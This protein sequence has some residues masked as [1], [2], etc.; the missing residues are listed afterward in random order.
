MPNNKKLWKVV[1]VY[2]IVGSSQ[3]QSPSSMCVLL[4]LSLK[5]EACMKEVIQSWRTK[6]QARERCI[7]LHISFLTL[8]LLLLL[9]KSS[10]HLRVNELHDGADSLKKEKSDSF[11]Y[12]NIQLTLVYIYS[13]NLLKTGKMYHLRIIL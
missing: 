1:A 4:H 10:L 3:P 6:V 9:Q 12:K 8:L 7:N 11:G 5:E 13:K 2:S